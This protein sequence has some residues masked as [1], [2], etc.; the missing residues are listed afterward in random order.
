MTVKPV[1]K[2]KNTW[3]TLSQ[4]L[5]VL[6]PWLLGCRWMLLSTA[7]ALLVA[8]DHIVTLEKMT[9]SGSSKKNVVKTGEKSQLV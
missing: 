6:P 9:D 8:V 3:Q 1:N 7:L 2:K 5:T 4:L